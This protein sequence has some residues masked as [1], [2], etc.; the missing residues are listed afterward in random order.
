[1]KSGTSR[2]RD[3]RRRRSNVRGGPLFPKGAALVG[4][5]LLSNCTV[6]STTTQPPVE[7]TPPEV[8]QP[9]VRPPDRTAAA[10]T[11][12]RTFDE[13]RAMWVV[14]F[15]M[16]RE[17]A[18]RTMVDDAEAAGI[19]TLLVQVRGRAD[20]FYESSLEPPGESMPE[21]PEFDPLALTTALAH[22]RGMAVHAWVNTHLVWGP[23]ARPVDRRHLLHT[24]PDWLAVPRDLG[25]ELA[26]VDPFEPRFV[27]RLVQY[28][29]DNPSTVEGVYSSPSHPEVQ[30]R[31]HA[32]WLDLA[33]RY[34]L[35]G[36]HFD[37]IRFPSAEYD[38]SIGALERFR[39]WLRGV[40]P[41][42]RFQQLDA[43]Y[44]ADLF[45]MVDGEAALWADFRRAHVTRLVERIHR[46]VK[47]VRPR[48]TI[49]A[50][51][52][53]DTGLALDDRFQEW[54]DWLDRGLI[55]VAVPMAYTPDA[56]RFAEL[57][58]DARR[59]VDD[60]TRVWAGIGAYMNPAEGTLDMIDLAR[61]ESLGGVVLFSYDWT[62][63]EGRGSGPVSYLQRIGEARFGR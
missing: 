33:T 52:I 56:D 27:D 11:P 17:D 22:E 50:A 45:A 41:P 57:V 54:P 61:R 29:A 2:K 48:L 6:V 28:A 23:A 9:D 36:I 37:Y 13:V 43:A 16:A 44:D 30:D 12:L 7:A 40:L 3:G 32:V 42:A 4:A 49:S 31:V 34:E 26:G 38:Y 60:P 20:A 10:H 53:A 15:T 51:V 58:R 1:M 59:T 39:L 24:H 5:V 63:G 14:R 25:R 19:N 18:I 8:R 46:D 21:G 35:D 47:A 62:V 55:D